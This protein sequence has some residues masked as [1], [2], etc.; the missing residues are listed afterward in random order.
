MGG[1]LIALLVGFLLDALLGDPYNFPHIVRWMGTLIA[2]LEKTVRKALPET[3]RGERTGG[4]LLATITVLL[5]TGIPFAALLFCYRLSPVFG[6]V[7]ESLL[8]WQLLAARSLQTESMKVH[9]SLSDGDLEGARQNLSMI[10][11]RDTA[12]LDEAGITRAAV[13]TVA[14]NASDG[15][16]APLFYLML[17]GVALGC[18][19]K[20]VNTMDSMV[21]YKNNRYLNFG[22]AAAK[23]DDALNYIPSRIA[24]ILMIAA[25]FLLRFDGKGAFR[26][27]RRD[28]R[29]HASPNSAQTESVCAGALGV[30]LAGPAAYFGVVHLK[31]YIGDDTHPIRP[32][33]IASANKLMYAASVLALFFA[34]LFRAII[35]GVSLVGTI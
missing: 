21:G 2:A 5:C 19:Y 27:W 28:R 20:A 4:V 7:I 25:S 17:G 8:C 14:E 6:C 22:C 18:L 10:V 31:P 13:E 30:R 26:I 34:L 33:D 23:L 24:A 11:G 29:K 15:V 32:D 16:I 12:A 9:R 35:W 3:S 1:S